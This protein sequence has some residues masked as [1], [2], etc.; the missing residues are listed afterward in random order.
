MLAALPDPLRR[1]RE[2]P[3]VKA[4]VISEGFRA[5]ES[6]RDPVWP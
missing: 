2:D 3:D 1:V 6:G 5:Y 4:L